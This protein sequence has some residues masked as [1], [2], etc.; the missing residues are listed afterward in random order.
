MIRTRR[1]S[2]YSTLLGLIAVFPALLAAQGVTPRPAPAKAP[3]P[4]LARVF[5]TVWDSVSARPLTDA[6]VR[7]VRSDDPSVGR[8]ATTNA[9]GRFRFDSLPG[10]TWI[11][12]FLHPVI[13]SLRLEPGIARIEITEAGEVELPLAIPSPRT[14]VTFS[15]RERLAADVGAIVG[16]VRRAD[17]DA[18]L[19]GATVFVEWPEW[20]LRNKRMVTEVRRVVVQTDSV[21][22]YAL[23][24]VPTGSSL[25]TL[26]WTS[27]DTSGA[28][29]VAV[30]EAGYAV[31]DFAIGTV[32]RVRVRLDS[33]TGP[34]GLTTIRRG[35]A[36]VRGVVRTL[37][38]RPL[39]NALVRVLGSGTQSRTNAEGVF[40]IADAAPGTQSV[41]ARAI[42]YAPYRQALRLR[43]GE[44]TP[45]V[46][47]LALQRVQLDTVR[48]IA[49][50]EIVPEV[51]AIERRMRTGVGRIL[52]ANTIRERSTIFVADAL[53]GLPGVA[54]VGV[55]YGQKVFM[56][57]PFNGAECLANIVIDGLAIQSGTSR[58]FVLDDYVS[59]ENVAAMEVYARSNLVPP[60]FLTMAGGCGVVAIWTKQATG[61]VIPRLLKPPTP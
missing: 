23:C 59:R 22:H 58:D 28:V 60:E 18:A 27:T 2:P 48:V 16:D 4:V 43:D 33:V 41:E 19:V 8:S 38:G 40:T 45:T 26:A 13:D 14:L 42:G 61:G 49:G 7:V 17:N 56:R 50:K 44:V 36:T 20:L 32:E 35:R 46:L 54:V 30:P 29:E 12:T 25:R 15:C 5:G 3:G 55:G 31:Q 24:G 57:S 6:T 21:G 51:R 52:D 9:N 39:A 47:R 10:G 34:A 1:F 11:A 53:R 37:D